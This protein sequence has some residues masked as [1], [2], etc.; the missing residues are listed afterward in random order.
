MTP[1]DAIFDNNLI[2]R[3]PETRGTLVENGPLADQTWFRVG[4]PAEVLFRPVDVEDLSY[5]LAHCPLDVPVTVLGAASNV[6]IR[7]GGMPGAK[8]TIFE[9]GSVMGE[10]WYRKIR[11][12]DR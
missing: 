12:P 5:F 1:S 8:I 10:S 2:D 11:Q 9:A 6:L 7:D 4:G 3:L